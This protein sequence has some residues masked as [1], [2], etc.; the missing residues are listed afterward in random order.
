MYRN[1]IG[2]G[3]MDFLYFLFLGQLIFLRLANIHWNMAMKVG[4]YHYIMYESTIYLV[5]WMYNA[6]HVSNVFIENQKIMKKSLQH[7]H[8][9]DFPLGLARFALPQN[10][11]RVC[12]S[13]G[14]ATTVCAKGPF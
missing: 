12:L 5:V 7:D 8:G 1:V 14:Y 9:S 11:Q 13:V 10:L 4:A 6:V 3:I 2:N